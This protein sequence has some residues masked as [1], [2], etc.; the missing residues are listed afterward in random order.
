MENSGEKQFYRVDL[1]FRGER[2]VPDKEHRELQMN[3]KKRQKLGWALPVMVWTV[4]EEGQWLV[5]SHND[6]WVS[7]LAGIGGRMSSF[8]VLIP[9]SHLI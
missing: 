2:E 9:L 6:T 8:L 3:V 4:K 5:M 7:D 1:C